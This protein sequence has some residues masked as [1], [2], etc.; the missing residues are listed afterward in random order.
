MIYLNF[1]FWCVEN[2]GK[3]KWK[4]QQKIPRFCLEND[5]MAK[6]AVIYFKQNINLQYLDVSR[7]SFF[8]HN[9]SKMTWK[10]K[11]WTRNIFIDVVYCLFWQ[12]IRTFQEFLIFASNLVEAAFNFKMS[13][14]LNFAHHECFSFFCN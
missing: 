4:F 6:I 9:I 10:I 5:I 8:W 11:G 3:T 14:L 12:K 2:R 1:Q 7:F 13:F